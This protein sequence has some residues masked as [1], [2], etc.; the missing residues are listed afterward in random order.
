[1]SS[2]FPP[3]F[4]VKDLALVSGEEFDNSG[5]HDFHCDNHVRALG[6]VMHALNKMTRSTFMVDIIPLN[7][8]VLQVNPHPTNLP[9]RLPGSI[10][11]RIWQN[12]Q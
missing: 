10:L 8:T 4:S 1:M 7:Q 5:H 11:A 9:C 2:V 6:H 12:Y 3:C